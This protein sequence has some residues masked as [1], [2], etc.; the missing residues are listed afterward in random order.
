MKMAGVAPR[1]LIETESCRR[2]DFLRVLDIS[3]ETKKEVTNVYSLDVFLS[4]LDRSLCPRNAASPDAA[5]FGAEI[6]TSQLPG[7][8]SIVTFQISPSLSNIL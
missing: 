3:R 2:K 5:S 1:R 6:K 8:H 7:E 4:V